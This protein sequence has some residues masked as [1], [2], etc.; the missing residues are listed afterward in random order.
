M[1]NT[2]LITSSS[3][4]FEWKNDLPYYA[5]KEY[6]VFL[7]GNKVLTSNNNV[8]SLFGLDSDTEYTISF[9]ISDFQLTFKTTK[10]TCTINVKDFGAIG[11]GFSDDTIAIQTAINCLPIGA[12]LYF[13]R[14]IY[15]SAPL[16]LKSHITLEFSEDAVLLGHTDTNKYPVI[17]GHV[18]DIN[19]GNDIEFGTW[20]GNSVPMHQS[21]IFAEYRDL[22]F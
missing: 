20:E 10:D 6:T 16:C 8:F 17:P 7:D 4:C 1:L 2:L 3:A 13:P 12:K 14:G 19:S 21:L 9:S 11:D 15:Y 22:I 18:L 5:E